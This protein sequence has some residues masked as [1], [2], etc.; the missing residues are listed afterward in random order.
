MKV[1][2]VAVLVALAAHGGGCAETEAEVDGVWDHYYAHAPSA[3][4]ALS[5]IHAGF[6]TLDASSLAV[7]PDTAGL[8]AMTA[9]V[10][11][12]EDDLG[13]GAIMQQQQELHSKQVEVRNQ[14]EHIRVATQQ[15]A[16]FSAKLES[17]K[18]VLAEN[19][20]NLHKWID[21]L[22][23]KLKEYQERLRGTAAGAGGESE[24]ESSSGA[25]EAEEDTK[26]SFRA[27]HQRNLAK[28]KAG[29]RKLKRG[30]HARHKR[31]AGM[32]KRMMRKK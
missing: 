22:G 23:V 28:L 24:S 9:T 25:A 1:A 7:A 3:A 30:Q 20:T 19:E 10:S 12:N 31:R 29:H 32:R 11:P 6:P 18:A 13:F 26:A 21:D 5:A 8:D 16:A 4:A 2:A 14:R 15:L 17:A 27:V